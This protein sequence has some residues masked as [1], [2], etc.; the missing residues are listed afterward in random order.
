[1]EPDSDDT[2]PPVIEHATLNKYF[3]I[4][5]KWYE[6]NPSNHPPK[7]DAAYTTL[8]NLRSRSKWGDILPPD[9]HARFVALHSGLFQRTKRGGQATAANSSALMGA[10]STPAAAQASAATH[11]S[12]KQEL[13]DHPEVKEE[14]E[15][16]KQEPAD[17]PLD[18]K[19]L[20]E[21]DGQSAGTAGVKRRK[22]QLKQEPT[23]GSGSSYCS[24][25]SHSSLFRSTSDSGSD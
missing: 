21:A 23:D 19:M 20:E 15:E 2:A 14:V 25:S 16:V 9:E 24:V 5:Q 10:E 3:E 4:L 8:N 12:V 7:K 6:L 18:V 1:M 13:A 22:T 17:A 11:G